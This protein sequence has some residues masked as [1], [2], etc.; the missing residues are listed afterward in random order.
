MVH[1]DWTSSEAMLVRGHAWAEG[2]VVVCRQYC[3]Q[4]PSGGPWHM[5]MLE[6]MWMLMVPAVARNHI[7]AQDLCS[8]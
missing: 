2:H 1:L 5:L 6:T 7:E 3:R 4:R 8:G